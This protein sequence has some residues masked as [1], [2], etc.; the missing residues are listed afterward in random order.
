MD[1][2]PLEKD[3]NIISALDDEPND[4]GGLTATELKA[5]FDEGG[6]AIKDYLNNTVIPEVKVALGDKAGKDELQGLVLGQIP[7]GTITED[8]LSEELKEQIGSMAP[9]SD[10]FTKEE[11]LSPE[12]AALYELD[13][14]AAPD[15]VFIILALGA[16]KYG[17]GITV[18]YP[19]GTPAA[20]LSVTGVTDRLG[21]AITTDENGYFLAVSENNEISFSIKSPYFDIANISNQAVNAAGVLT[22][23]TV[24]FAYKTYENYVL[25]TTSQ[26]M[27]F[28][29]AYKLDLTAVGGGGGSTGVN[30]KSAFGAGGGGGYV[31]TQL[32]IDVDTSDKLTVTIGAGGSI[33]Y[34]TNATTAGNPGGHT[35]VDKGSIRL[36]SAYGGTGSGV[37]NGV[38]FQGTGNGN[39]GVRS[40]SVVNP[41]N[42]TG[43][44]FNDASLGLAGGGG[45]G[46]F[47]AGAGQTEMK[48]GTPNGANGGYVDTNNNTAYRAGSAGVGGGG[49]AGGSQQISTK[50]DASPGGTGGV[51][52]RFKSA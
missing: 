13:D 43:F 51:Y 6:N 46:G 47:L 35:A 3:M 39:G 8:K 33:H 34:I 37:N 23:Q 49:G 2:T 18:K 48:G 15:D 12:T 31:E 30:T 36:V 45:G 29:R 17:Y 7:D 27:K 14:T 4:V 38:P 20:G 44:I 24:E 28:S 9:A 26:V 22:R 16:G 21:K 41:T 10:V 19:D 11:T 1:F 40:N 32:D 5:K 42:G 50:A 52:I 25:L